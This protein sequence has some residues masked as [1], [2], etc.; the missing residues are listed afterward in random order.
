MQ[1]IHLKQNIK[2]YNPNKKRKILIVFDY[3][4]ADKLSS[5]KINPIVTELFISRR[6]SNISLVFI[7]QSYFAVL[8]SIRLNSTHYFVMKIPNKKELQQI[9]FNHLSDID[10]QN[11]INLYKKC[12]LKPHSFLVIDTTLASNNSSRSR[13]NLL[14]RI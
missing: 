10:F 8:K 5:T 14:E 4:I 7:T 12:N 11:F 3:M 1:K 13:R 2:E 6:K 9:G